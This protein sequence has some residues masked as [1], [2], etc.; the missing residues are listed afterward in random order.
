MSLNNKIKEKIVSRITAEN[1]V[2]DIILFGS[3]AWGKPHKDSD[4]DLLVVLDEK[5]MSKSYTEKINKRMQVSK[6]IRE[7][8][9]KMPF[10]LL[11]YT[12][13]EWEKLVDVNSYFIR[14]INEHGLRLI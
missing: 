14:N 8:R 6:T 2:K 7:L 3:Y 12:K 13:D 10:D 5:G 11:V 9:K 1:K 4:I